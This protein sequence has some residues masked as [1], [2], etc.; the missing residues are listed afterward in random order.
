MSQAG[1]SLSQAVQSRMTLCFWSSSL[2]LPGVGLTDLCHCTCFMQCWRLNSAGLPVFLG[3]SSTSHTLLP[4]M[5]LSM[6]SNLPQGSSCFVQVYFLLH[7]MSNLLLKASAVL[8]IIQYLL[9]LES[10]GSLLLS[11]FIDSNSLLKFLFVTYFPEHTNHSYFK[12]Y[13]W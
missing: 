2:Y 1:L 12:V 7:L 4:A 8:L 9:V 5:L 11:V 6:P 13:T 10:Q 3:K